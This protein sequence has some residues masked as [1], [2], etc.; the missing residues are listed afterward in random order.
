MEKESGYNILSTWCNEQMG[1][2]GGGTPEMNTT[3]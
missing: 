1:V 2:E 3:S